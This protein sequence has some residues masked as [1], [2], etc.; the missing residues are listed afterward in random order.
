VNR[1][2]TEFVGT[3]VLVLTIGLAVLGGSPLAPLAIAASLVAMVYMGGHVSGAHYNPAVSTAL[4]L[5]GSLAINELAPYVIAQILG[6]IGAALSV[7]AITGQTFA[8]APAAATSMIAAL[9]VEIFYSTALVLVILNVATAPALAG[10]SFYGLAIGLTV[11]AGAL[12]GGSI[13]GAA[14]NPA[15]GLG[16]A[17]VHVLLSGGN[18]SH[19][20][21]YI[22]GPLAGAAIA[23]GIFNVQHGSAVAVK[24][25]RTE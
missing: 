19:V 9:L 23:V 17:L 14:F 25:S 15:V 20:W 5:R 10:N 16:P 18:V 24:K 2:L 21:L 1:Y 7:Y 3:F 11:G 22:V 4:V 8:P 12:A 13:S 6:A